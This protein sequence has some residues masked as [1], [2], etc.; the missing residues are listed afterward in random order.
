MQIADFYSRGGGFDFN[1]VIGDCLKMQIEQHI[2][3]SFADDWSIYWYSV[4]TYYENDER[5]KNSYV[6]K[7]ITLQLF[8]L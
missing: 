3:S 1:F 6:M 2:I 4:T 7:F 8:L 5:K